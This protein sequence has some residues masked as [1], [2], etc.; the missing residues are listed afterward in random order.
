[1]IQFGD[2]IYYIDIEALDKAITPKGFKPTDEIKL[3]E[4]KEVTDIEGKVIGT[5]K[6]VTTS[7][8][9][10]EIDGPKYD[11]IRMM[12][13]TIIDYDDES[14]T[15]LGADR[16]LYKTPLSYKLAFN[17]LYNYGIIKEKE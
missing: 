17:T 3:T 10:K 7:L 9:G 15:S 2:T 14:D 11:I 8:R 1:M 5:E 12:V 6:N 13:E 16:A 4:F